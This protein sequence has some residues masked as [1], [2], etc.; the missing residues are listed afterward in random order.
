MALSPDPR[1]SETGPRAQEKRID[2][3]F[4]RNGIGSGMMMTL[5]A[6]FGLIFLSIVVGL[7]HVGVPPTVVADK[8][9]DQTTLNRGSQ[10]IPRSPS[11]Q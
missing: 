4:E 7:G 10:P 2:E 8:S 1:F 5:G 9:L 11:A 6:V 3:E